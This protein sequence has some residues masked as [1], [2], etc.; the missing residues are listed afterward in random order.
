M[1]I[2]ESVQR[3]MEEMT[4]LEIQR[5]VDARVSKRERR[6]VEWPTLT[7]EQR[8]AVVEAVR[9][10]SEAEEVQHERIEEVLKGLIHGIEPG[11]KIEEV[12]EEEEKNEEYE[13]K[14][15][16]A[17]DKEEEA[18][19]ENERRNEVADDV[20]ITEAV[21]RGGKENPT[22]SRYGRQYLKPWVLR[23]G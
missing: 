8:K 13:E 1:P 22:H 6:H 3:K 23:E 11:K 14:E 4:L 9:E 21:N 10:G 2:R 17:Q 18:V 12:Q 5:E 19:E 16:E 15:E 20:E 7:D